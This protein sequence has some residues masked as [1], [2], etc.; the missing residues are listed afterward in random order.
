MLRYRVEG[1]KNCRIEVVSGDQQHFTVLI[2]YLIL[3]NKLFKKKI[4]IVKRIPTTFNPQ[5]MVS[6]YNAYPLIFVICVVR[7]VSISPGNN[8]RRK[9]SD[10]Y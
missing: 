9:F 5:E 8:S 3:R 10:L 2:V 1:T 4:T 6:V 7:S